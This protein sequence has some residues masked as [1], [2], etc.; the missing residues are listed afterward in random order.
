L[1]GRLSPHSFRATTATNLLSRGVPLEEVQYLLGH[2]EPRMTGL[3]GRR[4]KKVPR[5]I[6]ESISI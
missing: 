5:D 4:N 2:A 1:P 6:V 3:Y